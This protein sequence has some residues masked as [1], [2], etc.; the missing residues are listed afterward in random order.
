MFCPICFAAQ[1]ENASRVNRGLLPLE[2]P[3]HTHAKKGSN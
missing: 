3:L 1:L 2:A